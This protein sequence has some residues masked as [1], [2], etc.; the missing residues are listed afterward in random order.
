[1]T[2][3]VRLLN[4]R[5][6]TTFNFRCSGLT[7]SATISFFDDGRLPEV[8]LT[9]GKC[10]SD[11]DAAARDSAVVCS[12]ALQFGTPVDVIR[13]ALLRDPRGVASSP[14]GVALDLIA[15]EG[16]KPA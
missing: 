10:G 14:L 6:S 3:R 9:N 11:S 4:R 15:S 1:M 12:I 5:R 16:R 13:G 2:S 8:F 7:Y